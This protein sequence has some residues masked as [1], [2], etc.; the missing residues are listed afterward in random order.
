MPKMFDALI[1][2]TEEH[3]P[4]YGSRYFADVEVEELV[5]GR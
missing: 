4:W 5:M 3:V 2:G 1:P